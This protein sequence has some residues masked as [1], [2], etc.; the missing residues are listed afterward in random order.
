MQCCP[1]GQPRCAGSP[2]K[3]C[4]MRLTA[5]NVKFSARPHRQERLGAERRRRA[6]AAQRFRFATS[7]LF[8]GATALEYLTPLAPRRF[9][10]LASAANVGKSV[11]LTTY[12]STQ[13]SFGRSFA[14]GE[15][16]AD[17]TAKAQAR[18]PRASGAPGRGLPDHGAGTRLLA[19]RGRRGQVARPWRRR[20]APGGSGRRGGGAGPRHGQG[21]AC[22]PGA[23][24]C[25]WGPSERHGGLLMVALTC[26]GRLRAWQHRCVSAAAR[27]A[28]SGRRPPALGRVLGSTP[29]CALH[30]QEL[31]TS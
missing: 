9:L 17:I 2:L 21:A 10:L 13:P 16:L 11:G 22:H 15:N 18:P 27:G 4:M 14:R 19:G 7:L 5:L 23:S 6:G 28:S 1:C 8:T 24:V 30:R 31:W 12:I 3:H 29:V 26:A 20:A 25:N